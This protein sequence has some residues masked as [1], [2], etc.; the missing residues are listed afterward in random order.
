MAACVVTHLRHCRWWWLP[1]WPRPGA[2][3][4]LRRVGLDLM[5]SDVPGFDE[6]LLHGPVM[7]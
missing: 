6:R 1:V 5:R 4:A 3:R 7:M 2:R